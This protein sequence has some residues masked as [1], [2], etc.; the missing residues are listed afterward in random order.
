MRRTIWIPAL[1]SSALTL[2]A[3][4][5]AGVGT[6]P[7]GSQPESATTWDEV[8]DGTW[9]YGDAAL[10]QPVETRWGDYRITVTAPPTLTT[11]DN[12]AT[13]TMMS[14][15]TVE[16]LAD[17]GTGE[18]VADDVRVFFNPGNLDPA[19]HS[20]SYGVY[21]RFVCEP[22]IIPVGAAAECLAS[23]DARADEIQDS[24][25]DVAGKRAAAWLSQ[26]PN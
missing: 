8:S 4:S 25:W 26:V 14:P 7:Q 23:F 6:P 16:R 10:G 21:V 2:T 9:E 24:F 13:V 5:S 20:E 12:G 22:E 18:T 11:E 19:R 3:C 1:L 17:R 15:M